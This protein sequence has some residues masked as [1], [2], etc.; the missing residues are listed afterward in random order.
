MFARL[1]LVLLLYVTLNVVAAAQNAPAGAAAPAARPADG[2]AAA[3][4]APAAK[5]PEQNVTPIEPLKSMSPENRGPIARVSTGNG[6]LPNDGGQI[7]REYDISPYTG[8]VANTARPE[9]ALIDWIL[10][11]TGYESWHGDPLGFLSANQRTLRVYHTP[12]MHQ[13]VGEVVDR[14]VSSEAE[15]H[16]FAVRVASLSNPNWRAKA[17]QYLKPV[18]VESSGVQAW[19]IEKEDAAL[20]LAEL[21][22]RTDYREHSSPQL[23]VNN[24]QAAVVAATQPRRYLR[25][26]VPKPEAWPGYES[27]MGQI[28]EGFT[29]EFSPLLSLDGRNVDAVVKCNVDQVER[30]NGVSIDVP[31]SAGPRQQ[32]RVEVP[33]LNQCRLHERFRWPTDKVLLVGLGVVAT[34]ANSEGAQLL[35]WPLAFNANAKADLLLFVES[36]GKSGQANGAARQTDSR[37]TP[38]ASYRGRY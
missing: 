12:Q 14:F 17:L 25:G 33:Q 38:A 8:R 34:P 21:R 11:E 5:L 36:K 2:T 29:L 13:T 22:R 24:G 9:Q 16:A 6:S 26:I 23:L 3:G 30:L 7:Y 31:V 4:A 1:S 20:L 19:V 15:L 37:G 10:R 28:D 35:R 18:A 27:D 32:V